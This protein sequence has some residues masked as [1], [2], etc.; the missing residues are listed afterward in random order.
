MLEQTTTLGD[1]NISG[2]DQLLAYFNN[3]IN[4]W[5][6]ITAQYAWRTD[7]DWVH[8]DSNQ[9]TFPRF[10][11]DIQDEQADYKLPATALDIRQVEVKNS[12][13]DY[14][15][16]RFMHE[17]HPL[18]KNQKGQEEPAQPT[19]YR[20]NGRSL[21]L[22][23][24]P[25]AGQLTTSKGLRVTVNRE[26]D[27]FKVSDTTKEP[28][29]PKVFHPILYYGPGYEYASLKNMDNVANLCIQMLGGFEGLNE[30]LKEHHASRNKDYV[31]VIKRAYKSYK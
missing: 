29:I 1:G 27:A 2:N 9:T 25:D 22:Y 23:P 31:Q 18:L 4:Q 8:D 3:L 16:L 13:G 12:S 6:R 17:N 24:K 7:Q 20:L 28:G 5:L 11:T 30:I 14:Y 26:V 21:I 19:R 15:T 10:K